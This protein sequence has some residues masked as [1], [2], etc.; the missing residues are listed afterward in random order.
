[1]CH[2]DIKFTVVDKNDMKMYPTG[3]QIPDTYYANY[4]GE[5]F[6]PL[7]RYVYGPNITWNVHENEHPNMSEYWILQQNDTIIHWQK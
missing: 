4:P 1:M 6:I 3:L 5:L 7:H 2:F